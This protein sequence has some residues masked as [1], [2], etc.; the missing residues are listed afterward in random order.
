MLDI[1]LQ[2]KGHPNTSEVRCFNKK[3]NLHYIV[4]NLDFTPRSATGLAI[5]SEEPSLVFFTLA[6]P[7]S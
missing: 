5:S 2:A 1:A 7:I 6:S 3:R 4:L